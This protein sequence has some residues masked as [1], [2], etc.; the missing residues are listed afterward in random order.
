MDGCR[1]AKLS[2]AVEAEVEGVR[3]PSSRE[4]TKKRLSELGAEE[5]SSQELVKRDSGKD[6]NW[7]QESGAL[8]SWRSRTRELTKK[9]LGNGW[10]HEE[11][12]SQEP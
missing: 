1:R 9:R 5:Q 12:S 2:R 11:L 10:V 3:E 8:E 6:R 4:Q 7:V